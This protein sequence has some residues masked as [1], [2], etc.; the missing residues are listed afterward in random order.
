MASSGAA[1]TVGA[2]G[3]WLQGG[4]LGPMDRLLG[5]GIDNVVQFEVVLAD[6]SLKTADACSEPD[7]FWVCDTWIIVTV[8]QCVR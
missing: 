6:G 3:G 4:G 7:L 5:L 2:A 8:D 1:V